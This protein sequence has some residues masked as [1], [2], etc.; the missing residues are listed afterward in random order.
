MIFIS[1]YFLLMKEKE[2]SIPILP[3]YTVTGHQG[4]K[5]SEI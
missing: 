1:I 4:E 2:F 5:N 3:P